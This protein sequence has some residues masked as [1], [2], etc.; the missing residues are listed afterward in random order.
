MRHGTRG[1]PRASGQRSAHPL[2]SRPRLR[3]RS[4]ALTLQPPDLLS[5]VVLSLRASL[6]NAAAPTSPRLRRSASAGCKLTL[7]RPFLRD[8]RPTGSNDARS[9]LL[10]RSH[11]ETFTLVLKDQPRWMRLFFRILSRIFIGELNRASFLHREPE[12]QSGW[13]KRFLFFRKKKKRTVKRVIFV[14]RYTR[15]LLA[16]LHRMMKRAWLND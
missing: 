4:L 7:R 5:R 2:P 11:L 8:S 3:P 10:V 15:R 6:S 13:S 14:T 16:H 9:F 12:F 1:P